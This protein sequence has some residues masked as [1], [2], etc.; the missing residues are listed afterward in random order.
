[1]ASLADVVGGEGLSS[2]ANRERVFLPFPFADWF[3]ERFTEEISDG[4]V[5]CLS[6]RL[7]SC[8]RADVVRS[9]M[10]CFLRVEPYT[11]RG[12]NTSVLFSVRIQ[13]APE[14]RENCWRPWLL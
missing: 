7:L 11:W 2:F 1:M 5:G 8:Y 12:R 9:R 10:R 14:T 4:V 3:V 13:V 6:R